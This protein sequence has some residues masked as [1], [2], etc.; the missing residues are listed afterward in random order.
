[1]FLEFPK[2]FF[3]G[4]ATAAHQVEGDNYNDWTDWEEKNSIRLARSAIALARQADRFPEMFDADNYISGKACNHYNLFEK[5]FDIAKKLGHNAHR[6]SIEWS[7]IEPEEGKFNEAEIEHY[8]KVIRALRKRGIEPFVTLWHWTNPLWLAEK[9]GV[10]GEKFP[11]YFSRYVK[12]VSQ[13][14]GEDIKFWITVNE[15]NIYASLGYITGRQFPGK[16]NILLGIKAFG[17]LI[18]AHR[19]AYASIHENDKFATVGATNNIIYFDPKNNNPINLL[20][21]RIADYFWNIIFYKKISD[22][23]D[24]L[25]CNYYS[26]KSVGFFGDAK[27]TDKSDLGWDIFPEGIYYLLKDIAKL[28]KP[29]F[30]FENGIADADDSKRSDFIKNHLTSVHKAISE[31]ADIRGYFYWSLLDNFEWNKGF[32]PR[33]GLIEVD[34]KTQKRTIRKSALYYKDIISKNWIDDTK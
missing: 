21:C 20:M 11:F 33:F 28:K 31:G 14:L 22:S 26:K 4:A 8:R 2:G 23:S 9:G 17:N 7:R 5:D 10:A 19:A 18:S 6:F 30:I 3:W 12:K 24:F 16:R 27:K 1:M 34:Y 13:S 32:W 15:P 25:G 29:L